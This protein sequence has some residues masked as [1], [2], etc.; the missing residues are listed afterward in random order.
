MNDLPLHGTTLIVG[1]IIGIP[2]GLLAAVV[3]FRSACDLCSIEPP[4]W[5]RCLFIVVVVGVIGSAIGFLGELAVAAVSSAS[6]VA[7][8]VVAALASLP[9]QAALG[10]LLYKFLLDVSFLK[11]LLIW[12]IQALL[13][14]LIAG[15]VV[16]LLIG[17][18]TL[19]ES[20]VR[21]F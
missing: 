20:V 12:V 3:L 11:A 4:G 6:V 21:I 10:A 8:H 1:A 15:V 18:L 14:I 13:S 2:L 9:M 5:L 17:A 19:V 16:L 7:V